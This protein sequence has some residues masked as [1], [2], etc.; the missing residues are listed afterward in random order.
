ML[1]KKQTVS[2]ADIVAYYLGITQIPVRMRS[3]LREDKHPSFGLY[4][5]DGIHIYYVDWAKKERGSVIDLL[6]QMWGT[7]YNQTWERIV[8]D[9][10]PNGGV[11][12]NKTISKPKVEILS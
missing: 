6:R 1:E 12:V 7:D 3:P 4:S 11:R 8:R 10:P 2:D 9:I 5:R